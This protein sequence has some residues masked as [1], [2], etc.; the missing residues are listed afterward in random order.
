ML[1]RGFRILFYSSKKIFYKYLAIFRFKL[2]LLVTRVMC[3]NNNHNG[4]PAEITFP[5]LCWNCVLDHILNLKLILPAIDCPVGSLEHVVCGWE[6]CSS[7][8]CIILGYQLM[9]PEQEEH[10]SFKKSSW[11]ISVLD[12]SS[13]SLSVLGK[14]TWN[15]SVL[16]TS[17][18]SI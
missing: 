18:Y 11:S 10:I 14:C 9:E 12:T 13:C 2:N 3:H 16:D 17:S 8:C 6:D 4:S 5:K 1:V 15:I 7:I